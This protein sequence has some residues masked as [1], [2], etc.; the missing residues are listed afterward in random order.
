M[1]CRD[2]L[3]DMGAG[4]FAATVRALKAAKP[5][6]LVECLAPDFAGDVARIRVRPAPP[7]P[8]L[9]LAALSWSV[10]TLAE[11]GLDVFAHNIE[12]VRRLSPVVRDRR[13]DYDQTL[14]VPP[15]SSLLTTSPTLYSPRVR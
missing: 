5:G 10:Q 14:R 3:A 13:A 7:W 1:Y 9:S 8:P 12:C 11:S 4:H 2:D 15:P 6:L